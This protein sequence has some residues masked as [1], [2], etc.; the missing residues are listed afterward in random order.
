[1]ICLASLALL[2]PFSVALPQDAPAE[3]R[4]G[5]LS[6]EEG[7]P[8]RK[9]GLQM[10]AAGI[11]DGFVL[12][13]PLNGTQT[14]LIDR[15]GNVRHVW[16]HES[17]PASGSYLM[18]D[19][20]LLRC[21]RVDDE[22][23]F[24]GGGIGGLL[25]RVA[26]SGEVLWTWRYADQNR[27]HHHDIQPL[28]NGNILLIAWERISDI[29]ALRHGR[30]QFQV[31][32]AGLWSDVI[33]EVEPVLPDQAKIVWEWRAF[34]HVIQ[35][36]NPDRKRFGYPA[37]HPGRFDINV[38]HRDEPP[39]DAD[40]RAAL[41]ARDE[42]M[43]ALGYVGGDEGPSDEELSAL[44]RSGD[45]M[46]TNSI[47]YHPALDL[48]LLSSPELNEIYIIDHSTTTEQAK[49]SRGGR[50]GQGGE[51]LWRWGNPRNYGAG[52]NGDRRLWY[53][54]NPSFLDGPNG[55]LRVLVFNNGSG[56]PN[57]SYSSV[58]ELILPFDPERGFARAA[59]EAFGPKDLVWSYQDPDAF[60][61]AFISGCQR[62]ANGHTLICSGAAGRA[63]EIT[64]AG[65]I[66]WDYYNPLGGDV[67]PPD[68][69]GKAPP[70]ALFRA[71]HVA[72]NHPG[73]A[74]LKLAEART[75]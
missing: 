6:F 51:V 71:E 69:A 20:T 49:G 7:D 70:L 37:D 54:H 65:K 36:A 55:K 30:D 19:G 21:G 13:A 68:H 61:S 43:A 57:K 53:Q 17:S 24:R 35:D 58:E 31:G 63:F 41:T 42:G 15:G 2:T 50:W 5:F 46:H 47:D 44:D 25:Q 45:W 23:H 8:E 64:P 48:I 26:P 9:R 27:H 73:L 3:K 56:R 4:P 67:T 59:G 33:L 28:P 29:E 14:H 12:I 60:Y 74:Y 34:D 75:K 40:Q 18:E 16:Q 62:L 52:S 10:R 32:K 11:D 38:D 1:M 66:V 72:A 22:P 39:L